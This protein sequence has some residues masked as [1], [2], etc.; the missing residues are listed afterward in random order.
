MQMVDYDTKL[1]KNIFPD[2]ET[3]KNWYLSSPLSDDETDVP[4]EK[5]FRLISNEYNDCHVSFSV[6]SFKEH[7]EN[8]L[9]TYY[10][11]FEATSKS[12][13]ELM[14]LTDEQIS[15]AG[16]VITNIANIPETESTTDEET[17]DFITQQQKMINKKGNLQVKREQLSNKRTFTTK[18]FLNRF[19]HLFVRI[20][21][22][23][24]TFVVKEEDGE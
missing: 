20:I 13:I 10:R 2:Y 24:Y 16:N 6:E 15:I 19:R 3:F 11:E 4:S 7:F 8:D 22:P 23:A 5:T 9:Y 17:V 12:I 21:S 14:Q 1:F 18:T